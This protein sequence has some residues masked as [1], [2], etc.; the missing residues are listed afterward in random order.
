M[1]VIIEQNELH[2]FYTLTDDYERFN[3]KVA[4]LSEKDRLEYNE[5]MARFWNVQKL[6]GELY[7]CN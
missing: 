2:P 7:V 3:G 6:L 5:V 4:E 1:K